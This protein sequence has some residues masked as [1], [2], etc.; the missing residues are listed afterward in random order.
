LLAEILQTDSALPI[1]YAKEGEPIQNGR[2]YIAPANH[3]LLLD[4]KTMRLGTGPKENWTR[5]AID[6]LFRTAAQFHG[7]HVIGIIL[8]GKLDDGTAGLWAIKRRGGLAVVQDPREAVAFEMPK[9]AMTAVDVDVVANAEAIGKSLATWCDES[10]NDVLAG[11]LEATTLVAENSCLSSDRTADVSL[12]DVGE[13]AGIVCPECGGQLWRMKSGPL[14]YRC[15]VGHGLSAYS[16]LSRQGEVV[17]AAAWQ[18]VRAIEEE[19]ALAEQIL[20][21]G[22]PSGETGR[23]VSSRVMRNREKLRELRTIFQTPIGPTLTDS[24]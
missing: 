2:I 12:N 20:L 19:S 11:Q 13:I 15:H 14:R 10:G 4:K 9:H 7:P 23:D 24:R 8:S 3:H 16:L 17:E 5:P 6:P 1:G 18:L 21:H 22:S